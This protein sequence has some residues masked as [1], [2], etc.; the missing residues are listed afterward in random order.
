M[1]MYDSVT[2]NCPKCGDKL[3]EQ[4]KVGACKLKNYHQ[5]SV[6]ANIAMDLKD[7]KIS[8]PVCGIRFIITCN[9]PRVSLKLIDKSIEED[10]D[11]D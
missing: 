10:Y 2:F 6:P 4:S 5:Q 8:C 7:D 3:I 9:V 1:G 11:Y